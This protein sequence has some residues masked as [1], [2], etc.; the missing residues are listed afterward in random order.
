M[1]Y[2][3]AH[4]SQIDT[5]SFARRTQ[6]DA[7]D[8]DKASRVAA[9][10]TRE[11]SKYASRAIRKDFLDK[12]N[13]LSKTPKYVLCNIYKTLVNFAAKKEIYR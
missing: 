2:K 5:L 12:Y 13:C 6:Q 7:N 1:F 3:F 4:G 11:Q 8:P 10:I 9:R